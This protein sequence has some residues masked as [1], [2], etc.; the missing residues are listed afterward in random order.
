[1]TFSPRVM[2]PVAPTTKLAGADRWRELFST[3]MTRDEGRRKRSLLPSK[4]G[5][6]YV[7]YTY[8]L[9]CFSIFLINSINSLYIRTQ[10]LS[11][12]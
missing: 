3:G 8:Y 11:W 12:L 5:S 1:M 2:L 10:Q 6:D 4:V 9:V 7:N